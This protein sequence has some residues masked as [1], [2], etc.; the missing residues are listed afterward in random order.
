MDL[1][2]FSAV[3]VTAQEAETPEPSAA[4]AVTSTGPPAATP[5]TTP[6]ESTVAMASSPDVQ[7]SALFVAFAGVTLALIGEV[8]PTATESAVGSSVTPVTLLLL[9]RLAL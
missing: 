9:Y 1:A 3:T 2:R 7:L 8:A 6:E 5:V 4:V